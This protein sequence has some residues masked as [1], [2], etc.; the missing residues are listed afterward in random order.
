MGYGLLLASGMTNG[1]FDIQTLSSSFF[2]FL[3][4]LHESHNITTSHISY[5]SLKKN[6]KLLRKIVEFHIPP[7]IISS[8]GVGLKSIGRPITHLSHFAI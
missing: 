8:C 6:N 3:I 1:L 5:E 4:I 7:S 2:N